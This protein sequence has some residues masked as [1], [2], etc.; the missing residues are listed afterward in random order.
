MK[1][2]AKLWVEGE[3]QINTNQTKSSGWVRIVI[4]GILSLGVGAFLFF[5]G[6]Q[7]ACSEI[8]DKTSTIT[9]I[10]SNIVPNQTYTDFT[11]SSSRTEVVTLVLTSTELDLGTKKVRING[12]NSGDEVHRPS[13]TTCGVTIQIDWQNPLYS[14]RLCVYVRAGNINGVYY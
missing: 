10:E 9:P 8:N 6:N 11:V 13:G 5:N 14:H 3:E 1:A 12:P 7:R 2:R 4:V